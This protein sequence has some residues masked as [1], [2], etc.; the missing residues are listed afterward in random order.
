MTAIRAVWGQAS[1]LLE[2]SLHDRGPEPP[3]L[4]DGGLDIPPSQEAG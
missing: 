3:K 2:P 1:L 4:I